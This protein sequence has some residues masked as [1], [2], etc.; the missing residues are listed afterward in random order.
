[1]YLRQQE[2]HITLSVRTKTLHPSARLAARA[3]RVL[4]PGVAISRPSVKLSRRNISTREIPLRNHRQKRLVG[5]IRPS[6]VEYAQCAQLRKAR[7]MPRRPA[8]MES[9]RQLYGRGLRRETLIKRF[10]RDERLNSMVTAGE[11]KN[12]SRRWASMSLGRGTVRLCSQGKAMT[13]SRWEL[14]SRACS[15]EIGSTGGWAKIALSMKG[16]ERWRRE[17]LQNFNALWK[18]YPEGQCETLE[19]WRPNIR[20]RRWIETPCEAKRSETGAG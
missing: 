14:H 11:A 5:V 18:V 10:V 6:N 19:F 20:E 7:N 4:A 2:G 1:M 3:E 15:S 17:A 9:Q 8:N 12:L 13:Q 16:S